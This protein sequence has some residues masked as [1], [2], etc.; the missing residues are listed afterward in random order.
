MDVEGTNP[1]KCIT[2]KSSLKLEDFKIT[3]NKQMEN[4][5]VGKLNC[6]ILPPSSFT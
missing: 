6:L 5:Q 4:F 1:G 2:T 3:I